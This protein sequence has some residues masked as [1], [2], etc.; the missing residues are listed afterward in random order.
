M[1]KS[2]VVD[3]ITA[4]RGLALLPEVW[5]DLAHGR[6]VSD[7][8]LRR[9]RLQEPEALVERTARMLAPPTAAQSKARLGALLD[10]HFTAAPA[11]APP[12]ARWIYAVVA[13]VAAAV[14]LL[15]MPRMPPAPP[16]FD[17]G[18]EL[19]LDRSLALERDAEPGTA[20]DEVLRYRVDRTIQLTLRPGHRVTE[21]IGV[22]A[23]ATHTDGRTIALPIE[24][25]TSPLG[26]VEILGQPQA[27]GLS[28]G[29]WQ[30][31]VAVGPVAGLPDAL[32]DVRTDA[33][34]PYDV[35]QKWIE[36]LEKAPASP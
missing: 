26:V 21:A 2:G 22:R 32:P 25:R 4:H 24:P 1:P 13:L 3:E 7:E 34:A 11:S 29:R 8:A 23:F 18:Y 30:L 17:G 33:D 35:L 31:T 15:V 28:P 16:A 5:A 6:V 10:Q 9:A 12:S 14:V 20:A 19:E 27:W 36:I